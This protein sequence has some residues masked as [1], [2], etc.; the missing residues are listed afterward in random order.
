MGRRWRGRKAE[1]PLWSNLESSS[2]PL[3][4]PLPA[5]KSRSPELELENYLL[6]LS[7]AR[8]DRLLIHVLVSELGIPYTTSTIGHSRRGKRQVYKVWRSGGAGGAGGAGGI[9]SQYVFTILFGMG[10]FFFLD[11]ISYGERFKLHRNILI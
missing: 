6:I 7:C 4:L 9:P 3:L 2:L 8:F 1:Q 11:F 10:M 5:A